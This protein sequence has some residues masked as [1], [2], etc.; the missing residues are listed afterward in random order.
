M[1]HRAMPTARETPLLERLRE[2]SR[3]G[4]LVVAHR[5]D[6]RHFAENT[7]RAFAAAIELGAPMI[8]FDVRQTADGE[9]V[10]IHDSSL[11]RTS[12]APRTL[13]PGALVAQ[14]TLRELEALDCG[15]WHGEP[16]RGE[17]LPALTAAL[18]TMLPRCVPMIEHKAGTASTYAA[19]LRRLGIV[20][21]VLVQSFDWEFVRELRGELAEV[22]LGLLGPGPAADRLDERVLTAAAAVGASFLHWDARELLVEQVGL[23]RGAGYW[24]CTYTTDD[25]LGLI[26]GASLGLDAMCTNDPGHALALQRRGL[27]ARR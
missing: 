19:L 1:N 14:R 27:L 25:D 11:D 17:R 21:Q 7:L 23:A 5:G 9:F 3:P 16:S 12:D 15:S 10:C 13:G 4:P 24:L 20:E 18:T 8:E 2:L 6:S 26:G 22:T